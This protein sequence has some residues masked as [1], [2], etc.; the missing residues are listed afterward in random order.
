MVVFSLRRT[1]AVSRMPIQ[2]V[3]GAQQISPSGVMLT[4]KPKA[5]P[6][7]E[8]K[9]APAAEPKAAP[10]T[11]AIQLDI[12]SKH[13]T[14]PAAN[15]NARSFKLRTN[16]QK[17]ITEKAQV[18]ERPKPIK[19]AGTNTRS[20]RFTKV[21]QKPNNHQAPEPARKLRNTSISGRKFSITK[22]T[23]N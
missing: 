1:R 15:K 19:P 10:A 2:L 7:A 3:T 13:S 18:A 4:R 5:A 11:P 16:E 8:P 12:K 14:K 6:A 17:D 23:V 21:E 9:A 20:I 22:R